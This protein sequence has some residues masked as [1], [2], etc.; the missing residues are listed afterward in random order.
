VLAKLDIWPA[1]PIVVYQHDFFEEGLDNLIAAIKHND[2][3]CKID[4]RSP[5]DIGQLEQV[6]SLMGVPFPAL[7]NLK[8]TLDEM[9]RTVPVLPDLFLGGSA[10]RLQHLELDGFS[11]PGL[12]NLLFFFFFF[13]FKFH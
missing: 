11:F 5:F 12:P 10:P 9:D 1:L 4:F 8:L 6:V 7:S 13:F 3:V 2:R